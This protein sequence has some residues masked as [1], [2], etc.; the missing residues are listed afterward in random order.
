MEGLKMAKKPLQF[1]VPE[2][3]RQEI[4]TF[5]KDREVTLSD[6]LRQ[7]VRI[8]MILNQYVEQGYKLVLRKSNSEK[9]II[10]P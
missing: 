3:I 8:Y 2:K 10:L 5:V 9:E 1:Q 6:F 4:E 7:S